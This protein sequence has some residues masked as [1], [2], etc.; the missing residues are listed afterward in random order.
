MRRLFVLLATGV[1]VLFGAATPAYAH[2][3]DAPTATDYRV[4]VTGISP[5][6]PGLTIRTVEA[7][8]RL[9]LVNDSGTDVEVLGY[10][11]EPYLLIRP[12]GVWQNANSPATYLNE[13]LA[14]GVAPPPTAGAGM[15]PAWQHLS[16]TPAVLWHDQRTHWTASR[17]PSDVLADPHRAHHIRDWSIPLRSGTRTFA[18]TGTLDW[19]PAPAA[20]TW[21]AGCLL[22]AAALGA[23]GLRYRRLLGA[24]ALAAGAAALGYALGVALDSGALGASGV[25]RAAL[26]GQTWPVVC[27]LAALAAGGYAL[28]RRPAADLALGLAGACVAL[29]AGVANAAV[30][31][32]PVLPSQWPAQVARGLILVCVAGGAGI[33]AAVVLRLRR[34]PAPPAGTSPGV[35]PGTSPRSGGPGDRRRRLGRVAV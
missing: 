27:G 22:L 19:Q 32:H 11:G 1:A 29:F 30:F 35:A 5:A 7:G 9:E 21:W 3:A 2:S 23:L 16:G 20:G 34:R 14:G 26:T 31:A 28:A 18:V 10:S 15:P 12:D 25:L 6:L 13:S 24:V 8:A 33:V 17:P 4:T